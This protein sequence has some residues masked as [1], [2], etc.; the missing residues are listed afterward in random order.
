MSILGRKREQ[1]W[2]T[3]WET[4]ASMQTVFAADTQE[5]AFNGILPQIREFIL[6]KFRKMDQG[7][8]FVWYN[9]G[10]NPE[11]VLA[12]GDVGTNCLGELAAMSS[13]IGDQND[14]EV[15]IDLAESKGYSSSC[16]SA[17]KSGV[18]AMLKGLYPEPSCIV[19]INTPCDSQVAAVQGMAE[20]RNQVPL[21][22]IDIPPYDDERTLKHVAA[23]LKELVGF[24][25]EH[26]GR[27]MDYDRL[28]EVCEITNKT[29]EQLWQW[30]EWRSHTPTMQPSKLCSFT[31]VMMIA[32]TGTEYG[33]GIAKALADDAKRVVESGA[34][35]FEEKVRAI[36]YQ[37][38][39]WWD[40]QFYD[41]MEMELGLTIPMDIFG[42]Y[43]SEGWV[44]T[45]TEESMFLGLARRM[46]N[47]HPMSRQFRTNMDRYI[48]D[49]M[50][51]HDRF[52]ADCGIMAG[53]VACKHA[54]GGIG[55]F[56]EA[57]KKAGIPLLI[58]EFDMFDRRVL[59][60]K[61]L[62]F[63]LRRF[64]NEIVLPRKERLA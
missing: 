4:L 49:F 39:I 59:T 38:P 58:F 30:M 5:L 63:E 3:V 56:R 11:L 23:Q 32:F 45:S 43:S 27:K 53:H 18:G 36:W 61:E 60:Y 42:Y 46:A 54:W 50:H 12:L 21:Y 14:T 48:E 7:K 22:V 28:R 8:P 2:E 17:D 29:S 20:N 15:F 44:D 40:L 16:C 10:F 26:T 55:M 37:D 64:V 19:G 51:L 47:C 13:I 31:M 6:D 35:F 41:W 9:L 1:E 62:Q 25:E 57:C 34:D 24:L 33:L 52:N